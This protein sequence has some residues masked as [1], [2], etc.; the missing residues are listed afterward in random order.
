MWFCVAART[1]R[2]CASARAAAVRRSP[3]RPCCPSSS[4]RRSPCRG[5]GGRTTTSSPCRWRTPSRWGSYSFSLLWWVGVSAGLGNFYGP[6]GGTL[7]SSRHSAQ[8][9]AGA[10]CSCFDSGRFSGR[11]RRSRDGLM[12]SRLRRCHWRAGHP[13]PPPWDPPEPGPSPDPRH[14][15]PRRSELIRV[16]CPTKANR[17]YTEGKWLSW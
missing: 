10:P 15:P 8:T 11:P 12:E 2:R 5:S 7:G 9:P 14:P 17:P 13:P 1:A 3:T 16:L 6:R 4:S